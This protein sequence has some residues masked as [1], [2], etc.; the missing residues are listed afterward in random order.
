MSI[1][2]IENVNLLLFIWYSRQ[3]FLNKPHD[4]HKVKPNKMGVYE[5][6]WAASLKIHI[7]P[8]EVFWQSV[9]LG[10]VNFQIHLPSA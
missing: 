8:V 2:N 4:P 10:S 6:T 1:I 3:G 5:T 7:S 9:L